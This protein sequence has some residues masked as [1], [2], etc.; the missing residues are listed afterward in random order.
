MYIHLSS[1]T[2]GA[3]GRFIVTVMCTGRLVGIYDLSPEPAC[4]T[5]FG[6]LHEVV[7]SHTKPEFNLF[8]REG[9]VHT[10]LNQLRQ[11]LVTVR[12]AVAQL[13]K[14]V[15]TGIVHPVASDGNSAVTW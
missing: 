4:S 15:S 14:A 10:V 8:C 9:G 2:A 6:N 1:T 11:H 12:E 3:V 13:L 7:G 5:E